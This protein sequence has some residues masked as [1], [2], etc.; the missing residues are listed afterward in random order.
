MPYDVKKGVWVAEDSGVVIKIVNIAG[1]IA[2]LD[3]DGDGTV[4]NGVALGITQA[5]RE[6]LAGLYSPGQSLWRAMI[7]HFDWPRDF[8]WTTWPPADAILPNLFPPKTDSPVLGGCTIA[9][10]STIECQNQI[11]RRH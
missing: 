9:G 6:R 4:D 8:N 5:E 3:T 1:G 7:P 10:G 11:V 2:E